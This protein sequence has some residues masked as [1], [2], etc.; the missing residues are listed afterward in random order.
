VAPNSGLPEQELLK[1]RFSGAAF[2]LMGGGA[3]FVI[4][5]AVE[6]SAGRDSSGL[7]G[8]FEKIS[9]RAAA[10]RGK[11]LQIEAHAPCGAPFELATDGALR[12][13]TLCAVLSVGF[14]ALVSSL[15]EVLVEQEIHRQ[16]P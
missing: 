13:G 6:I 1:P 9:M 10:S 15:D 11:F 3:Q 7:I 16:G 2:F 14:G 12:C 4:C 8:G 5:G